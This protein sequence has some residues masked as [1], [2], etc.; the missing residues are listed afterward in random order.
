[1]IG[2]TIRLRLRS[3][4]ATK[5]FC[6]ECGQN[7]LT[8]LE[9]GPHGRVIHVCPCCLRDAVSL[10]DR[11]MV[12]F[13]DPVTGRVLCPTELADEQIQ[14]EFDHARTHPV[15]SPGYYKER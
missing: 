1:M 5:N 11:G 14:I 8:T 4:S 10:L 3:A 9:L 13:C 2:S 6:D 15:M 7:V 12:S